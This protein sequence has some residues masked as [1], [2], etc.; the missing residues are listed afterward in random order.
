MSWLRH[1]RTTQ[2]RRANQRELYSEFPDFVPYRGRRASHRLVNAWD[3]I[4]KNRGDRSWKNYRRTQYKVKT[5]KAKK[6]SGKY[7]ASM[8]R[9][10]HF[11]LDHR[12]CKGS[13]FYHPRCSYCRKHRIWDAADKYF[14]RKHR[15]ILAEQDAFYNGLVNALKSK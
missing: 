3:D 11:D 13:W 14:E 2:E 8:A 5:R 1:P 6:D 15:R 12:W 7:A 9:R 10:D 4:P